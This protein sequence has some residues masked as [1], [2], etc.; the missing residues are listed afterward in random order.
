MVARLRDIRERIHMPTY[1]SLV[2]GIGI[3][4]VANTTSLFGNSVLSRVTAMNPRRGI[5][6]GVGQSGARIVFQGYYQC[7]GE[8]IVVT[9]RGKAGRRSMK[10]GTTPHTGASAGA[11]MVAL[12]GQCYCDEVV[13]AVRARHG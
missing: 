12:S 7:C 3:T 6:R 2:R 8:R 4:N 13:A 5:G 11:V 10:V 9:A 1:D